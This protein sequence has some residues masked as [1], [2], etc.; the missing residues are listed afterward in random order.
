MNKTNAQA[1]N[2][3]KQRLKKYLLET[4]D[5]ENKFGVQL[6]KYRENPPAD[7]EDDKEDDKE[8]SDDSDYDYDM[9]VMTVTTTVQLPH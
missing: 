5:D 8:E 1:Y 4:G 7:S 3:V 9:T 2:R 6:E